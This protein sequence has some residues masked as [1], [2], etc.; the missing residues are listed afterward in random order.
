MVDVLP[1]GHVVLLVF[2]IKHDS[3][4]PITIASQFETSVIYNNIPA[5]T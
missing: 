5:N 4:V 1:A 2:D 3:S